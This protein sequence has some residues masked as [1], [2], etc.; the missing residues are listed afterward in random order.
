MTVSIPYKRVTN[1]IKKISFR[2]ATSV[3]IPYKRVTNDDPENPDTEKEIGF[4]PL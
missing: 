1:T 3:S 4:N 2:I